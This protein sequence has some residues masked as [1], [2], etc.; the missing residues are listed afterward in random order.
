MSW[1]VKPLVQTCVEER[2]RLV[3]QQQHSL[4]GSAVMG[5]LLIAELG[6]SQFE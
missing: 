6:A 3:R 1:S 5:P 4:F 2:L